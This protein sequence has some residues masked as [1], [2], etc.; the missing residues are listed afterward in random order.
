MYQ[1]EGIFRRTVCFVR[2]CAGLCQLTI[3]AIY[4]SW[5]IHEANGSVRYLRYLFMSDRKLY[6]ARMELLRRSNRN[7]KIPPPPPGKLQNSP[8]PPPRA[9]HG[10][11][12]ILCAR[13]VGNLTFAC[14]G[15]GKLNRKCEVGGWG[16]V[17]VSSWAARFLPLC[18]I[19]SYKRVIFA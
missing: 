17:E 19:T 15:W 4:L 8:P 14:M 3:N 11:L 16:D 7:F 10:H 18:L 2:G 12:T 9:N 5:K 6:E 13:G 1:R